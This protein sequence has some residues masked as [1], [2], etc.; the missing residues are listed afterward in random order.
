MDET[1]NDVKKAMKRT[2]KIPLAR[3]A[4]AMIEGINLTK[5]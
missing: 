1:L 3:F 5:T 4:S 2:K